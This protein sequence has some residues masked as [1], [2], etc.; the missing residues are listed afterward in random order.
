MALVIR[1]MS[2]GDYEAVRPMLIGIQN[3]HATARPDQF[4][5][6]Q[7]WKQEDYLSLIADKQTFLA[8]WDGKVA[9]YCVLAEK[10]FDG[11]DG[12]AAP[13]TLGMVEDLYVKPEMRRHGIG[14]AL[15]TAAKEKAEELGLQHFELKVWT[16]NTGAMHLYEKFGFHAKNICMELPLPKEE[17]QRIDR[18]RLTKILQVE[19]AG[20]QD[21]AGR[22]LWTA[23]H[24]VR[25]SKLVL[26]LRQAEHFDSSMDDLLFTA[27]LFHDVSH[28]AA[29]H[30]THGAAGAERMRCLLSGEVEPSLLE[31]AAGIVTEHDDRRPDD[32]RSTAFHLVQDA[33]MLD[34]F[35]TLR[36]W[37]NYTYAALHKRNLKDSLVLLQKAQVKK[38]FY[39]SLLHFQAAQEAFCK[40]I[41]EEQKFLMDAENE[42]C[43]KLLG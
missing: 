29:P 40:R 16:F 2:A 5:M 20:Q 21:S 22:G 28:D 1:K 36:I 11:S 38:E 24:C 39:L 13:H 43:G 3:V 34:H 9:G 10:C 4:L 32:G 37:A 18:Q 23:D 7:E 12:I 8:L 30:E 14:E 42:C 6:C 33:D 26:E 19:L 35:G 17:W 27:A 25:V 41:D 15:L 31:Q